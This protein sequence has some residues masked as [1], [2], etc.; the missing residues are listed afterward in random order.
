MSGID[1]APKPAQSPGM[2]D[3]TLVMKRASGMPASSRRGTDES[4]AA[5][6]SAPASGAVAPFE[7]HAT[8]KHTIGSVLTDASSAKLA[9][10]ERVTPADAS[11]LTCPGGLHSGGFVSDLH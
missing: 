3:T 8:H 4:I 9:R 2:N 7:P 5:A 10:I 1:V 6:E 11:F